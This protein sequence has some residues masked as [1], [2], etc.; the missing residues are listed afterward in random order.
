M[1]KLPLITA[2]LM[3][4]GLVSANA[5]TVVRLTGSTAYRA[6][7]NAALHAG[8]GIFDAPPSN[9]GPA[10]AAGA[11]QLVFS[12]NISGN[13][14]I[15]KTSFTGS[16]A[17]IA[18]LVNVAVPNNVSGQPAANL[19]GTPQ[20]SFLANDGSAGPDVSSP[21]ISMADTSQAVSLTQDSRVHDVGIVGVVQFVWMKG[22]NSGQANWAHLSNVTIPQINVLLSGGKQDL[23]FFTGNGADFGSPIVAVGRNK[24]SGTRVNTLV[25]ALYGVGKAVQQYAVTPTYTAGVL[26]TAVSTTPINDGAIVNIGNDG[27]DSGKGVAQTL[28]MTAGGGSL[29][30]IPIGY[31]GL[32]DAN[33]VQALLND[34]TANAA[35][36][37]NGQ[38][39]T[40]NGVLYSD[41][42][43][44]NGTYDH[45]GH[46]HILTGPFT[47]ATGTT[48]ANR[49]KSAMPATALGGSTG[50]P[51]ALNVTLFADRPAGGDTGFVTPL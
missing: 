16:E 22:K 35:A 32:G 17:G 36:P 45:W 20:P 14:V 2:A 4:A 27:F 48:V 12:G 38:Y 1:N 44:N 23:S 29:T 39:L 8:T 49:L 34:G 15:V 5:Q 6:N 21:D 47:S 40:V 7:V 37:A 50:L 43:I 33:S 25:Q 41:A 3:A 11:N 31:L 10:Y 30:T 9:L 13:P 46:E 18:S 51:Y 42:A 19:P 28:L 26:N 24:G